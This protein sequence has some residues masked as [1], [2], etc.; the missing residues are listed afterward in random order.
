[1]NQIYN[2]T[3]DFPYPNVPFFMPLFLFILPLS[4]IL[5]IFRDCLT[6]FTSK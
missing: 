4:I 3:I 1:M 2:A 5:S 6:V